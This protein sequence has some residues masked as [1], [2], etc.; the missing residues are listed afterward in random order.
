M[1]RTSPC[2]LYFPTPNSFRLT[3][4]RRPL[5][6]ADR[7]DFGPVKGKISLQCGDGGDALIEGGVTY[8]DCGKDILQLVHQRNKLGVVDINPVRNFS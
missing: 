2:Q 1:I 7:W 3:V 6:E 4:S 8:P 5:S